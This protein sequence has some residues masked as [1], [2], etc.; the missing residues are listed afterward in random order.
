MKA[1]PPVSALLLCVASLGAQAQGMAMTM[2]PAAS[3]G[4]HAS[5]PVVD[6]EIR[7]LDAQ[8]GSILLKHGEI[9]NLGMGPMT[10]GFQIA[11][12]KMLKGLKVGDKVKFRAEM[13]DGKATV[14]EVKRVP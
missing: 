8:K 6:A 3:A 2:K 1:I 10:M 5:L 14:T 13:V 11:D 9:P 12:K 7:K 4:A